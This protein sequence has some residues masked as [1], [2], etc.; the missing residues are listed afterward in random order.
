M[1]ARSQSSPVQ[2]K[3]KLLIPPGFRMARTS[4]VH[5]ASFVTLAA[6][7]LFPSKVAAQTAHFSDAQT[8]ISSDLFYPYGVAVDS[9]GNVYIADSENN[10]VLKMTKSGDTYTQSTVVDG[11]TINTFVP[12]GVAVDR[13]GNVYI[14]DFDNC[15]VLKETPTGNTYSQS[16]VWE[17]NTLTSQPYGV[18]VDPE[19]NVYIADPYHNRV[20]KAMPSGSSYTD[21]TVADV[22]EG[23]S[24]PYGVAV[25][26]AGN[27]YIT[28]TDNGRVLRET[29][30]E[31]SY[32]QSGVA[33]GFGYPLG[34]AVDGSGNVY[35]ADAQYA[36]VLKETLSGSSYTQSA[37][38]DQTDNGL[39][40]PIGLAV[41]GSGN[42]YIVDRSNNRVLKLALSGVDFGSVAVGTSSAIIPLT[43]TFESAGAIA[44]PAVLTQ[45]AA[46]LDFTDAGTGSCDTNG[47]GH[48]Y[49]AGD[50]CTVDLMFTPKYVGA[51]Y[52]AAELLD[53]Y[54]NVMATGYVYGSGA[55]PQANFLPGIMNTVANALGTLIGDFVAVDTTGDVFIID[56]DNHTLYK[57]TLANGQYTQSTIDSSFSY[58]LG[59]A[60]D[61]GGNVYVSDAGAVYKETLANG[62]YTK[63][64]AVGGFSGAVYAVVVDGSGDLYVE[65]AGNKKVFKETLA[66]GAYTQT[67]IGTGLVNPQ[68]L[69]IDGAEDIYIT[70]TGNGNLYEETLA[71]GQYT[72]TTIGS[73][74]S[75]VAVDGDGNL[76]AGKDN[77]SQGSSIVELRLSNDQYIQTPVGGK[78]GFPTSLATDGE[79]DVY[80]ADRG[81]YVNGTIYP[82]AVYKI[83]LTDPPS[84]GFATI[85]VGSAS[86]DSPQT[87]TLQNIGNTDLTFPIPAAGN[88]PSIGSNF[89]LDTSSPGTCPIVDSSS[90]N[91]GILPAG[92]S[93]TLPVTF[94][95]QSV[96]TLNESLILT[97]NNLNE[98]NGTQSIS[99]SGTATG[100]STTASLTPASLTFP[101][102][103]AGTAGSAQTVTLTNTSTSNVSLTIDNISVSSNFTET[104]TCGVSLAQGSSC[105]ISVA[106]APTT[107][108]GLTGTLTVQDN[109][110]TGNGQQTVA[111]SA[112]SLAPA[113]FIQDVMVPQVEALGLNN[114]Q[115][116]SLVKELQKAVNMV[117]GGKIN[118]AIGN[119]ESFIAEVS[120]LA[121]SGVLSSQEAS[122]LIGE[123]FSVVNALG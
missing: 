103:L 66:D 64:L 77:F 55:G 102:Q 69:A 3:P 85:A 19:G 21:S 111:L 12:K 86:T 106:F 93:C 75:S 81:A 11:T 17:D 110:S 26:N 94:A 15:R 89:T 70:D 2:L 40:E 92:M 82:I 29:P 47:T 67:S 72:Q 9:K 27:V 51:R 22:A 119:L 118:G 38:A 53:A 122:L 107:T 101:G 34:V 36:N 57:E 48:A 33:S 28:D 8:T 46:N 39:I 30:A 78:L 10:R 1:N 98:V 87:V 116:N 13:S 52:G 60:V 7:L 54:G 37:I 23:L 112:T 62:H 61:G 114:G 16:V 74:F 63:S 35:V 97:D 49:S 79:G 99:L 80:A 105:T 50:T 65:D 20:L 25:D 44:A 45:G 83:D 24:S 59:V 32:T 88:N 42:L 121:S 5:I 41:D 31:S 68:A 58:P 117:N 109:A 113:Q 76:F 4:L 100:S 91:P 123:A 6:T 56:Y 71:N 115:T 43:F 104:T 14:A 73:G 18:A 96:G 90:S 84:L 120:D 108:G 95:P